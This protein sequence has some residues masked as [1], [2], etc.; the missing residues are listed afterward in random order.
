MYVCIYVCMYV[1]IFRAASAAYEG[2]QARGP[3]RATATVL[4]HSHSNARSEPHL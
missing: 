3:I 4:L 1:C 2:S